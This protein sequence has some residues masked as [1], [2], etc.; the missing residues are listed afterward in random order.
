MGGSIEGVVE[1]IRAE[2]LNKGLPTASSHTT[3]H[4]LIVTRSTQT[5]SCIA[6]G[7]TDCPVRVIAAR[8]IGL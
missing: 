3:D 8:G 7:I 1:L 2:N 6:R 5:E 4:H